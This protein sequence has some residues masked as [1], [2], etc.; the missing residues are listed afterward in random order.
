MCLKAISSSSWL[1][2]PTLFQ[3]SNWWKSQ[4][5]FTR[6]GVNMIG[7]VAG[8]VTTL[9]CI[10][11]CLGFL[12]F[13]VRT[14]DGFKNLKQFASNQFKTFISNLNA[15]EL[16]HWGIGLALGT[17]IHQISSPLTKKTLK[18]F[19]N[20]KPLKNSSS[21]NL[22]SPLFSNPVTKLGS[23]FAIGIILP[24]VEE[25]A[26]NPLEEYLFTKLAPHPIFARIS[27]VFLSNVIFS[28]FH[29]TNIPFFSLNDAIYNTVNAF[30]LGTICSLS[31]LIF[32]SVHAPVGVHVG[33]N[34]FFCIQE[35]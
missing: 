23:T 1:S 6:L 13:Q 4:N 29:L 31:K 30:Y 10:D 34:L 22:I 8:T 20:F 28:S 3:I 9:A 26:K 24:L 15:K 33:N 32:G 12:G 21:E 17:K 7:I 14:K 16:V 27:S 35:S 2:C 5:E 25:L 18:M 11:R 19:A